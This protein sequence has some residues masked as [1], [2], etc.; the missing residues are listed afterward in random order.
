MAQRMCLQR[1]S[2][3]IISKVLGGKV[4]SFTV[5]PSPLHCMVFCFVSKTEKKRNNDSLG[6]VGSLGEGCV[7][8]LQCL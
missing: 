1:T 5:A 7:S 6:M 4:N 8:C 2:Q 3:H